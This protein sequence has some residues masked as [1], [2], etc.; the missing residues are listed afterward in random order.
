MGRTIWRRASVDMNEVG[1]TMF[2]G[3]TSLFFIE[4]SGDGHSN[5]VLFSSATA[6]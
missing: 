6:T 1:S 3:G 2:D 4:T 5:L